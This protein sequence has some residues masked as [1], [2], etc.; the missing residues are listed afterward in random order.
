MKA[1]QKL[2]IKVPHEVGVIAIS[3]GFIPRLYYPEITYIETSGFKL[4]KLAFN[5][6]LTY[7]A[8]SIYVQVLVADAILVNGGSL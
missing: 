7:M 6:M 3:D 8:G 1:I 5:R 2:Q 4:A